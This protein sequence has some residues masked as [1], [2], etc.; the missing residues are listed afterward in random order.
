MWPLARD[1]LPPAPELGCGAESR[2]LLE[3]AGDGIQEARLFDR[4]GQVRGDAQALATRLIL[5]VIR[6]SE[7]D[8]VCALARRRIFLHPLDQPKP[9]DLGHH[10]VGDHQGDGL[11]TAPG[12]LR[13][14]PRTLRRRNPATTTSI[15]QL[16]KSSRRM[17]RLVA[18]S[19]T[20]STRADAPAPASRP[21]E[22]DPGAAGPR[23][24]RC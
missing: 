21:R 18:L 14:G 24:R 22:H 8:D 10:H 4:L 20:A 16:V 13:Q 1:R 6:R 11:A 17:R 5:R 7:H 9:I 3:H 19:S 23:R 2:I 15:P 12:P